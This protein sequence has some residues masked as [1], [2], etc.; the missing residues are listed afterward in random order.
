MT[1]IFKS[2]SKLFKKHWKLMTPIQRQ[3]FIEKI[4]HNDIRHILGEYR[5][6]IK[7]ANESFPNIKYSHPYNIKKFV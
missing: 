7:V 6:I 5:Q 1:E 4:L 2:K 3:N